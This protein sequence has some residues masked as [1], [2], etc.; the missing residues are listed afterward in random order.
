MDV[1]LSLKQRN[2]VEGEVVDKRLNDLSFNFKLWETYVEKGN[3][4]NESINHFLEIKYED[5]LNK[6]SVIVHSIEKWGRIDLKPHLNQ[7]RVPAEK[8]YS[9]ELLDL[10]AN[11]AT[12]KKWYSK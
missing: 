3:S 9:Q 2:D 4:Y 10:S 6:N 5:L 7:V 12:Y 11:S 8:T 1:A